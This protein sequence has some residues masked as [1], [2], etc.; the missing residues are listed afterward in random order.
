MTK[1]MEDMTDEEFIAKMITEPGVV[2]TLISREEIENGEVKDITKLPITD[3]LDLCFTLIYPHTIPKEDV[4][5][6]NKA[7]LL[8]NNME[9]IEDEY[10]EFGVFFI[11]LLADAIEELFD[12]IKDKDKSDLF[13]TVK[14]DQMNLL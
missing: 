10:G 8:L 14:C 5:Y 6:Q 9:E 11:C 12:G 3:I 7:K 1:K 2:Q 4:K 13:L